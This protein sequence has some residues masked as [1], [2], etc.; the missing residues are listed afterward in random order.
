MTV[1]VFQEHIQNATL[2][3]GVA[4]GAAADMVVTPFG[5]MV[6]GAI[7]G[8]LST[9]GY[10]HISVSISMH[11]CKCLMLLIQPYL[12]RKFKITDTC[13]VNNLHGMPAI[14]GGL[15]SV[16]MAGIATREEYDQYNIDMEID[17]KSSLVEIFPERASPEW[18]GG[19]QAGMQL[20]AMI[21]TMVFAVVGGFIT[22]KGPSKYYVIL[23]AVR[24]KSRLRD[25][26][27]QT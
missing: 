8:A 2:A 18:T 26:I 21:V 10:E 5:T 25:T 14:L 17:S 6:T 22:G 9:I 16:L 19:T 11:K 12:V 1:T 15:L 23:L 20:A 27:T 24:A 13:G 3:G 7:A 4:I